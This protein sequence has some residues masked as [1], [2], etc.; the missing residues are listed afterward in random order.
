MTEQ[1]I[2]EAL[3]QKLS[4]LKYNYRTDIRDRAALEYNFR[5]HFEAL[6]HVQLTDVEFYRLLESIVTPDVYRASRMLRALNTHQLGTLLRTAHH[7]ILPCM[8]QSF[9]HKGLEAFYASGSLAGI[10]A[11]STPSDT[12]FS[13]LPWIPHRRSAT[14]TSQDF[15][16]ILFKAERGGTSRF[17]STRIGG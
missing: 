12:A 10:Q 14:W 4:D 2:E 17:G 5:R 11:H 16:C 6:N 13:W 3:I 8:I 1:E 7:R 9:G 15:A